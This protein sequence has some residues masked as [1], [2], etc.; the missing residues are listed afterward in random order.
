MNSERLAELAALIRYYI[1]V[2]T[3]AAGSGHPTSSLSATDLMTVLLFGGFFRADLDIP[4]YPNNDRLIFSK[5]HASPLFYALYAAAGKVTE[6]E[7]LSLRKF[8]SPLEGHPT[9]RF[10]YTEA[11]TGSLGQGLSVG[12]G[13][14]LNGKLDKLP[15]KTFVLLG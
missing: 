9:M 8:D 6:E 14:A 2:S 13:M 1:I 12:V 11:A 3:T 7:L 4:K 10:R 15:Y 5:G